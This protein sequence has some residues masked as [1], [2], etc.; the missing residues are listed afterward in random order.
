MSDKHYI[1]RILPQHLSVSKESVI[2]LSTEFCAVSCETILIDNG[3]SVNDWMV[4]CFATEEWRDAFPDA[5]QSF[6]CAK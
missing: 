5:L 6:E 3:I 4:F 2:S 1:A